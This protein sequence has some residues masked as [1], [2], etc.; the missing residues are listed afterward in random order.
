MRSRPYRGVWRCDLVG[1]FA[2]PLTDL[3][4]VEEDAE[5][6][7]AEPAELQVYDALVAVVLADAVGEAVGGARVPR[8]ARDQH[9]AHDVLRLQRPEAAQPCC[10]LLTAVIRARA[11]VASWKD[12]L[13]LRTDLLDQ[14]V[15]VP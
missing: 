13:D 10:D 2:L 4:G 15:D 14:Q 8:H 11:R 3:L 9:V 6:G 12:E 7:G 1:V 5:V